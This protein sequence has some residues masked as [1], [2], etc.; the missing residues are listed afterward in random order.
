MARS[1]RTRSRLELRRS[2][3]G[4]RRVDE[5]APLPDRIDGIDDGRAVDAGGDAELRGARSIR[6]LVASEPIGTEAPRDGS[7]RRI[8]HLPFEPIGTYR[9]RWRELTQKQL[10]GTARL[11]GGPG[12]ADAQK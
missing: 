12:I 7:E 5:V 2:H 8:V 1:K 11:G 3:V 4:G 9:Q 10:R 6:A